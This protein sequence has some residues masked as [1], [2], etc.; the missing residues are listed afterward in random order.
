MTFKPSGADKPSG[1][2]ICAFET[3]L[4]NKKTARVALIL[5]VFIFVNVSELL[6]KLLR[7]NCLQV[8]GKAMDDTSYF[9]G[10][11]KT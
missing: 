7:L 4:F 9:V 8:S 11:T 2:E 3:S 1:A 5:I 10:L 6:L